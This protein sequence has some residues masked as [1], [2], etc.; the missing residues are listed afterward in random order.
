MKIKEY[1]LNTVQT[2]SG[3]QIN[4]SRVQCVDG[5]SMS[6]QASE[7]HYCTPCVSGYIEYNCVEI[8]FPSSEESLLSQYAESPDEPTETVY[9]YVP[10]E[11]VDAV[12]EKHGGFAPTPK[13]LAVMV[14]S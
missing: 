6:V 5:Y 10:I 1:L 9:G 12:I 2:K 4:R 8:G 11:V 7:C 14:N 13:Y 3:I